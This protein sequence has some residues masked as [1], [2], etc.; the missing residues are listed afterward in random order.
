MAKPS[1][2]VHMAERGH[3]L[4]FSHFGVM[5]TGHQDAGAFVTS[6]T[7]N[8]VLAFVVCVLGAA[9]VKHT[10]DHATRVTFLTA[11]IEPPKP[12]PVKQP[13]PPNILPPILPKPPVIPGQ[14]PSIP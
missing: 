5:N 11:P 13:P 7:T 6:L 3:S 8:L 10:M 14:P 1:V 12:V 4:Q 9:S 2:S